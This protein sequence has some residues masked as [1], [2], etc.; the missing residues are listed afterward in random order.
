M[1]GLGASHGGG[2][3]ERGERGLERSR[4]GRRGYLLPLVIVTNVRWPE[5]TGTPEP[6]RSY[7][8]AVTRALTFEDGPLPD[9]PD[10]VDGTGQGR[11]WDELCQQVPG[12]P[13]AHGGEDEEHGSQGACGQTC[14]VW[15]LRTAAPRSPSPPFS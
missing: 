15:V 12:V 6:G 5:P 11:V 4:N 9:A 14:R 3:G 13:G 2:G 7:Q 10:A 1:S 8:W